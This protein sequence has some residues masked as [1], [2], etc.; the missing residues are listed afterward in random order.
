MLMTHKDLMM[1]ATHKDECHFVILLKDSN[2][3]QE[4]EGKLCSCKGW[5]EFK[6]SK[7]NKKKNKPTI[8]GD[9]FA[10][11]TVICIIGFIFLGLIW[12][13]NKDQANLIACKRA[14]EFRFVK[15]AQTYPILTCMCLNDKGLEFE[16]EAQKEL[17]GVL[18][19][20]K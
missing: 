19:E 5:E 16:K 4:E 17:N 20:K 15:V 18:Q 10:S 8:T 2:C 1:L 11:I 6:N 13:I 7:V 9:V 14:C 3:L 12:T